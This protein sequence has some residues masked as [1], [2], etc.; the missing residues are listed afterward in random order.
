VQNSNYV[1]TLISCVCFS[2]SAAVA[3][4]PAP[5]QP[6]PVAVQ[7]PL[8]VPPADTAGQPKPPQKPAHEVPADI[9]E[10]TNPS[11]LTELAQTHL[12]FGDTD[13]AEPLLRKVIE[14]PAADAQGQQL[15]NRAITLLAQL[16][17]RKNDF[18]GAAENYDL[19]AKSATDPIEK[20]RYTLNLAT[21]HEHMNDLDSAAAMID[22]A[23][24]IVKTSD[25]PSAAWIRRDINRRSVDIMRR[26]PARAE[27]GIKSAEEALAKN[28]KDENALERLADI[29]T[30]VK[31]D[32]TKALH[33]YEQLAAVRPNSPETLM[34]LSNLYQQTK[35]PEK[36]I[37][38]S[39]K[40]MESAPK[41]Q[42]SN[43]AYQVAMQ[44]SY[45]GKKDEA[46]K[47]YEEVVGK[48]PA[49]DRHAML[50]ATLYEQNNQG[51]QA[52]KMLRAA[53][54]N[55]KTPEE[56]ANL[57][58]R[59]ADSARRRKDYAGAEQQFRAI[60]A[61]FKDHKMVRERA[62]AMLQQLHK[63]QGKT[64]ELKLD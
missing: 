25:N 52:E 55:A 58:S 60:Y 62:R 13:R 61:E 63:E 50:L 20:A 29:Y 59:A 18:K 22:Q 17:E 56:K 19:A 24:A 32:N 36:A 16:L 47:F 21:A 44:M 28:P 35:Q 4:E 45:A 49:S 41:E 2:F 27:A 39:R 64:D 57:L 14:R 23:S 31:T 1:F 12:N 33:Y 51:E 46:I 26:V 30:S 34:R 8:K 54:A 15:K 42:Q 3:G 5:P 37:E 11:Y 6:P 9:R 38:T 53:A 7:A 48:E 43:Y 40:L 10:M